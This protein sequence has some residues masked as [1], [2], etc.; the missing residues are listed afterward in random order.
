MTK[1]Y[2]NYYSHW[3]DFDILF[4]LLAFTGLVI[5]FKEYHRTFASIHIPDYE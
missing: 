3:I 4:S 5:S 1:M 2:R